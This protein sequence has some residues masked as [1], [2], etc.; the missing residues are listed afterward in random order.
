MFSSSGLFN[1]VPCPDK[2]RCKR[3]KCIFSHSPDAKYQGIPQIP[4]SKPV[5]GPSNI[6]SQ[7]S[8]S[9]SRS[10][11]NVIVTS[12]VPAKRPASTFKSY[13]SS[14]TSPLTNEPPRKAQK[15]SLASPAA[16]RPPT[17]PVSRIRYL[18]LPSLTKS[19]QAHL[20][21]MCR[22]RVHWLPFPYDR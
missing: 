9:G 13:A 19:S 20:F 18:V 10:V 3:P 16:S 15:T 22:L 8:P 11:K 17:Q 21:S 4:V 6:S 14:S 2:D 5:A 1:S 7:P 12:S